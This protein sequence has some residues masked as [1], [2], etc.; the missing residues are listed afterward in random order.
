[1]KNLLI[2]IGILILCIAGKS[3]AFAQIDIKFKTISYPKQWDFYGQSL[4]VEKVTYTGKKYIN[5]ETGKYV[6]GY[7]INVR[8]PSNDDGRG[9]V[10]NSLGEHRIFY[11]AAHDGSNL[12]IA[13]SN[14][15]NIYQDITPDSPRYITL[16]ITTGLAPQRHRIRIAAIPYPMIDET[17]SFRSVVQLYRNDYLNWAK[18]L[19]QAT[20][21]YG[22]V[23][24][25]AWGKLKSIAFDSF[26][27]A[28]STE[29]GQIIEFDVPVIMPK[30]TTLVEYEANKLLRQHDLYPNPS[31][32]IFDRTTDQR[33]HNRISRQ[34]YDVN[35]LI[36]PR[37][38]IAYKL[39]KWDVDNQT[40]D[41]SSSEVR[42]SYS[43]TYGLLVLNRNGNAFT[44]TYESGNGTL[45]GKLSGNILEGRWSNSASNKSGTFQFMFNNDYS[46]FSGKFGY[47]NEPKTKNWSSK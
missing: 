28:V 18:D 15:M 8:R 1:M 44:G 13:L 2:G 29:F 5:Q 46:Q 30:I 25:I 10:K 23:T 21:P 12:R 39:W 45:Q 32:Q 33:L 47:N 19:L 27:A 4:N 36:S 40:Q 11:W 35:S 6:Y 24:S 22:F 38:Y 37:T 42:A 16:Y 43:T 3:V 14:P 20:T 26:I 34:Q 7:K 41:E 31:Y 17:T 9:V